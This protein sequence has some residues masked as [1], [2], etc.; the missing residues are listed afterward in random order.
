MQ[1]DM[2]PDMVLQKV[3]LAKNT[4]LVAFQNPIIDGVCEVDILNSYQR[5]SD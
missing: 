5:L 2:F 3:E 4:A 1:P